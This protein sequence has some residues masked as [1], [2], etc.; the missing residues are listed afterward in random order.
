M[1]GPEM[2]RDGLRGGFGVERLHAEQHDIGRTHRFRQIGDAHL[3]LL[4]EV[5]AIEVQRVARESLDVRAAFAWPSGKRHRRTRTDV[6]DLWPIRQHRKEGTTRSAIDSKN[7]LT[8]P[9]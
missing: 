5:D 7:V 8:F 2:R 1:A 6:G 9:E 4:L 3:D